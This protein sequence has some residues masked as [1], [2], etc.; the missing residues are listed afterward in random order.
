MSYTRNMPF[1]SNAWF[2]WYFYLNVL[3]WFMRQQK[4]KGLLLTFPTKSQFTTTKAKLLT[5]IYF[6]DTPVQKKYVRRYSSLL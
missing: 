3:I 1:S 4:Q 5:H 6:A 2:F